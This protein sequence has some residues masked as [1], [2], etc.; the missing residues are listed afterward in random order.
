MGLHAV[1]Q[2]S[3]CLNEGGAQFSPQASDK[4]FNRIRIAVKVL[5]VDMFRELALRDYAL[6]VVH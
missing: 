6:T 4:N 3:H 1:T 5:G 2:A